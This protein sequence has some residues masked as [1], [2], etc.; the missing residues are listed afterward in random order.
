MSFLSR[1]VGRERDYK[2]LYQGTSRFVNFSTGEIFRRAWGRKGEIEIDSQTF[3][4]YWETFAA[5]W[6]FIIF[7]DL[8]VECNDLLKDTDSSEYKWK[9]MMEALS[10]FAKVSIITPQELS[11]W[12]GTVS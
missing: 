4:R 11:G 6:G 9:E 5:Y 7:L 8:L 1:T 10:P 2:F 12:P 3:V